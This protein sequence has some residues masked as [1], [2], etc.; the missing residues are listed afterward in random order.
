MWR[1]VFVLFFFY[2]G[3]LLV[4]VRPKDKNCIMRNLTVEGWQGHDS[5]RSKIWIMMDTH[6][7]L[8]H[9]PPNKIIWCYKFSYVNYYA[10]TGTKFFLLSFFDWNYLPRKMYVNLFNRNNNI[11]IFLCV[12][13]H[14]IFVKPRCNILIIYYI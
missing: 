6:I 1:W 3:Y 2:F 11:F 10:I 9:D 4:M 8:L 12:Q 7:S 14:F 5:R 13:V